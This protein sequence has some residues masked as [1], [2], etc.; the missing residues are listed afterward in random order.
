M[1]LSD[2]ELSALKKLKSKK[3]SETKRVAETVELLN[4][5]VASTITHGKD[6]A[7]GPQGPQ[8]SP[9]IPGPAGPE[10]P[11]GP[12]GDTGLPGKDGIT[13]VV[14]QFQDLPEDIVKEDSLS[15]LREELKKLKNNQQKF[16]IGG[17][18]S[19]GEGVKYVAVRQ[20]EYKISKNELLDNGITIFGVNF[21]GVVNITIPQPKKNQIVYINDESGSADSNNI[22]VTTIQ[23]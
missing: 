21:A 15:E 20:A 1:A 10:G 22:V 9:G 17:G 2:K 16:S 12:K 5:A 19:S 11:V 3:V 8:G 7:Q 14:H 4:K 23:S 6:G 13:Q 18:T